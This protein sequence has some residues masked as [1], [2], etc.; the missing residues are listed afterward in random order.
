MLCLN[1]YFWRIILNTEKLLNHLKHLEKLHNN[2]EDKI[3][4]NFNRYIS[5]TN[6]T[7]LKL[8]KLQIKTE[9]E[10]LKKKYNEARAA[11]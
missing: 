9:I 11:H 5:D 4:D 7:K 8:E 6:L 10:T 1:S 2:I 3:E